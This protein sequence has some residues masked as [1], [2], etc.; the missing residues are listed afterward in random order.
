MCKKMFLQLSDL[1]FGTPPNQMEDNLRQR[2][3]VSIIRQLVN[4]NMEFSGLFVTGDIIGKQRIKE[5][6]IVKLL[7]S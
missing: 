1:H 6:L 3:K 5:M 7:S 4:H 2:I